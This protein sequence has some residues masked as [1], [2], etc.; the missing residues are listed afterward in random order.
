[1]ISLTASLMVWQEDEAALAAPA[2]PA[3]LSRKRPA[4]QTWLSALAALLTVYLFVAAIHLMGHGLKTVAGVPAAKSVMERVFHLADNP[5]AGLSVGVL[6]TSLV[7]SSS[8]T[9]T[10][11]VGLVAAGQIELAAAIP[12]IMG[13]NI[14]TS[15]TNILVSLAHLRQRVEFRRSLG[16]A[17]VHDLFNVLS[18][19][20]L[21]PLEWRYQIVSRPATAFAKWLGGAAFFT[22]SP[23]RYNLVKTAVQ[24]LRNGADWLLGDLIGLSRIACG[25]ATAALAVLLLF[26]ALFFLVKILR[27]L[28]RHRLAGLFSRTLFAHPAISFVVGLFTTAVVQS[29]SVTTS[30]V[31]PLVGAGVLKIRQIYPYTLGANIGTTVTAIIGG[32]AIAATAAGESSTTQAAAAFGL[33]V[34]FGHLLFNIY[35]T[36]VFWPL[37]WIPISLAKGY[38]KLASRRRILAAVYILV[39]FFLLPLLTIVL[40]NSEGLMALLGPAPGTR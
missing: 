40:V 35:G 21:M 28:L 39:I 19:A 38:A 20:L 7:Q 29:S 32:L 30:L 4:W 15:V 9:T 34:A 27:G 24:P 23:G 18:V 26:V 11:T 12:I 13:A 36:V 22:A 2:F 37:Q 31:V 6:I 10:F 14:G 3:R 16:G 17:I 25:L 8:F 1:M 33:A 5:L